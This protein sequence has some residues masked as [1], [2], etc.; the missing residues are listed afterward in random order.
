MPWQVFV[1]LTLVLNTVQVLTQRF[2]LK[3]KNS[4]PATYLIV[5]DLVGGLFLL[6][7]ALKQEMVTLNNLTLMPSILLSGLL[8]GLGGLFW[9]KSL[10]L[11]DASE[12]IVLFTSRA[13]WAVLA[14]VILLGENFQLEQIIGALL[15]FLGI[16]LAAWNAKKFSFKKGEIYALAGAFSMGLGFVNDGF[17]LRGLNPVIYAPISFFV[18]SLVAWLLN[19][20]STAEIL[21]TFRSKLLMKLILLGFLG[22]ATQLTY[23]S[24]VSLSGNVGQIAVIN[25]LSTILIV[26]AGIIFLKERDN[27]IKKI[28]AA[29]LAFAGVLLV[30]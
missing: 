7:F 25:Q 3:D 30:T 6:V 9:Y 4:N 28:F 17:I 13:F 20:K 19:P 10:K 26:I 14:S 29:I 23:L 2:L 12:F 21:N 16:Y 24:A 18:A 15:I 22:A 5:G 27:L 1:T 8:F 11:I